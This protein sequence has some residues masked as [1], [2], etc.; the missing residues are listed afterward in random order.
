[1][2]RDVSPFSAARSISLQLSWTT[3]LGYPWACRLIFSFG[4]TRL[5]RRPTTS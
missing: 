5:H 4:I 3:D 2:R 1:M